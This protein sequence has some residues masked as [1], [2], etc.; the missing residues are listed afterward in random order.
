M[1]QTA[2]VLRPEPGASRTAATLESR[3][4]TAACWPLFSAQAIGWEPP[5][6]EKYDAVML[7]SANTVLHGGS[8]L[9]ALTGLPAYAVGSATAD[10]GRSAGFARVTVG[11]D[12]ALALAAQML[13]DGRRRIV[14]PGGLH[15]RPLSHPDLTIDHIAVYDMRTTEPDSALGALLASRPLVLLH[16]PRAAQRFAAVCDA[17][18]QDR[19]SLSLLAI[20]RNV[21]EAA[22]GGWQTVALASRKSDEAMVDMAVQ[23]CHHC[24]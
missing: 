2:L 15:V 7:T 1:N 13:A 4:I 11:E 10:A 6:P 14:H 12:D 24:G 5:S 20:S 17:I 19:A 16:S 8:G 23:L 22:E 3:G 9:S 18:G 21:A